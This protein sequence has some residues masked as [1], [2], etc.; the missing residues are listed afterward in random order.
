M[1]EGADRWQNAC[2]ALRLLAVDPV[3]LKGL[4]LRAR[5]GPPRQAFADLLHILPLPAR[6]LHPTISD[7]QLFG[8]IDLAATLA[9]DRVVLNKGLTAT[10]AALMLSMA[11]RAGP[12][13]AAKLAQ[14]LD[15]D[16]GHCL[17]M[18]DE[19]AGD[20]ET[21]P[22]ALKERLA[23]HLDL[24]GIGAQELT[25]PPVNLSDLVTAR[26]RLAVITA[27]ADDVTSLVTIALRFGIDSLR[28]PLL[29]LRAARAHAALMGHDR[30]ETT[31]VT[32]AASLVYPSRATMIPADEDPQEDAPQ[33]PPP[34]EDQPAE[35]ENPEPLTGIPDEL[36]IEAVRALLPP[37]LLDR[38]I[39]GAT[40]RGA[41]GSG[42]AGAR[43]KGNRRGRPLPSRPGRL[44][45]IARIDLVATLRA[46]APW[47]PMR[48]T[49]TPDAKGLMIRPADIRLKRYEETSDR[50][51]IFVVDASGSAAMARL[52]EAKGAVELLLA[53]AYARRDHVALIAFRGDGAEVLLPPTRSL[54]QTKRRLAGLPGGGG[55]PLAA[56]LKAAGELAVQ[57]R[58]R[59]LS[60]TLALLTDGRAN[61]A[62]DGQPNRPRAATDAE[63]LARMLRAQG[64]AGLVLDVSVR[65]QEALR[66][67]AAHMGAPYIA[68][69]RADAKR[70]SGAISAALEG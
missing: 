61:I 54:V 15:T 68:L 5:M 59:G 26:Q 32:A 49:A 43:H 39:A 63:T 30:I 52:G 36:L 3:G 8:G 1:S 2:L 56:G 6:K 18:L 62:L 55:T 70:L 19:G 38:I 22:P 40:A 10:P 65:P 17:V 34:P 9:G 31:D 53:E 51:L 64:I 11:E 60:P 42:G 44:D 37:H 45:G 23:F 57:A 27:S 12:D 58:G 33:D 46:A 66:G 21:A 67:L 24:D 4:C 14:V 69:P 16:Q 50:L 35:G 20:E 48:R 13:L 28:A 47:Q 41:T 7:E 25:T 29:A